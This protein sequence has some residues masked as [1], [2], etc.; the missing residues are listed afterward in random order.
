MQDGDARLVQHAAPEV[1]QVDRDDGVGPGNNGGGGHVSVL[2]IVVESVD[3]VEAHRDHR[4]GKVP[5]HLSQRV[6]TEAVGVDVGVVGHH[7]A[8]QLLEDH[9]A[10]PD[11]ERVE[12]SEGQEEVTERRRVQDAR[13]EDDPHPSRARS[14][15]G[16]ASSGVRGRD[17]IDAGEPRIA[18]SFVGQHVRRS[19]PP[20]SA[21]EARGELVVVYEANDVRARDPEDVRRL[22][23]CQLGVVGEQMDG[24]ASRQICEELAYGCSRFR[25]Q[26][27]L[28][29]VGPYGHG[30]AA[31]NTAHQGHEPLAV[32]FGKFEGR[33]LGHTQTLPQ[34]TQTQPTVATSWSP[35]IPPMT[36]R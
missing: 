6:I 30:P 34:S 17:G 29:L 23:G 13:V 28:P 31:I 25:R 15:V 1:L 9:L 26:L 10:P 32:R 20:V 27:R 24:A 11:V 8:A 35:A 3:V 21:D 36:H 16:N 33:D 7:V 2:R 14:A 19:E 5:A 18:S 4:R 12:G 22:L